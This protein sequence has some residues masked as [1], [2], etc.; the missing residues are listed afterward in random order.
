MPYC[1]ALIN[2]ASD[3]IGIGILTADGTRQHTFVAAQIWFAAFLAAHEAEQSA[4]NATSS[5]YFCKIPSS[6]QTWRFMSNHYSVGL[7]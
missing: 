3:K 5:T 6:L 2:L 1:I 7:R 4:R